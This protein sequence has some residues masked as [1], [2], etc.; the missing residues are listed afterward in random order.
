MVQAQHEYDILNLMGRVA[1][2]QEFVSPW[3]DHITLRPKTDKD[4]SGY[5]FNIRHI[6]EEYFR[7]FPDSLNDDTDYEEEEESI[8]ENPDLED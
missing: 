3:F 6:L 2:S 7:K 1:E 8:D 5:Y 4:P